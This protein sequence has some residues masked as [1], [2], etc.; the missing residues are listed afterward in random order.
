MAIT[1]TK[2]SIRPSTSV[3]FFNQTTDADLVAFKSAIQTYKDG[4]N[5]SYVTTVS[6]DGLTQTTVGT[7]DTLETLSAID[8]LASIAMDNAFLTYVKNNNFATFDST[9]VENR[10]AQ[11]G[12]TGITQEFKVT[13]KYTFPSASA[14]FEK[15]FADALMTYEQYDKQVDLLFLEDGIEVV[16]QYSNSADFTDFCYNDL[17]YVPQLH[18]AG[19]TRTIK[20]ELV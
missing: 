8:S 6:D 14:D 13:T 3:E 4:G 12:Q 20:Y 18:A 2:V 10:R 7:F 9:V 5:V 1:E 15:L 17:F 16:H 11:Y 19:V